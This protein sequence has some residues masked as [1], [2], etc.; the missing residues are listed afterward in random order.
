MRNAAPPWLPRAL[1][2]LDLRRK[3]RLLLALP[4]QVETAQAVAQIVGPQGAITVLEPRRRQAE[5][6]AEALPHA[7]VLLLEPS[8]DEQFGTFDAVLTVALT[9]PP[10]TGAIWADLVAANLRPGGRFALDLPAPDPLPELLKAAIAAELPFAD[11]LGQSL[12]GPEV[13]T[14]VAALLGRGMRRV[15]TLLG[16]HLLQLD[17]PFD[18]VE[19]VATGVRLDEEEQAQLAS[20]LA[21]RLQST[22]AA[23][24]V[25]YRSAVAGMR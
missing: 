16:T 25:A 15:E 5:A 17:S 6:I 3:D 9:T 18:L 10:L 13:Q 8:G 7:S 19:L 1:Q 4:G 2:V 21:R 14:L 20:A 11:R 12:A 23:Q 22:A 24:T